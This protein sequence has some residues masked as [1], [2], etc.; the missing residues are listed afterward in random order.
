MRDPCKILGQTVREIRVARKLSQEGLAE[1]ADL[2]RTYVGQVERGET[3][4]SLRN[5]VRLAHALGVRPKVLL[6]GL[7]Q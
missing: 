7:E 3:N 5:L 1:K 2:H 4:I 6:E